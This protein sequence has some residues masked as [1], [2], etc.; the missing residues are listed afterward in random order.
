MRYIFILFLLVYIGLRIGRALIN[1]LTR[2]RTIF[3]FPVG[4]KKTG[5]KQEKPPWD[6]KDIIDVDYKEMK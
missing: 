2:T 6:E 3:N 5:L 1:I 4:A